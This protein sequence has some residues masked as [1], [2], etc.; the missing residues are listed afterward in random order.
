MDQAAPRDSCTVPYTSPYRQGG[1]GPQCWTR[2]S[3]WC[4]H[5]KGSFAQPFT[6]LYD[7]NSEQSRSVSKMDLLWYKKTGKNKA[8]PYKQAFSLSERPN[9]TTRETHKPHP[10]IGELAW[11]SLANAKGLSLLPRGSSL[12]PGCHHLPMTPTPAL[13]TYPYPFPTLSLSHLQQLS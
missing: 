6:V 4:R 13:T 2:T 3:Q 8:Y 5:Y 1:L 10:R 7:L 11:H 9:S 12:L